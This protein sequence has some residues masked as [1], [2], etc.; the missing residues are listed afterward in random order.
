MTSGIE[1]NEENEFKS[2]EIFGAIINNFKYC[3]PGPLI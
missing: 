3:S 1:F 2:R